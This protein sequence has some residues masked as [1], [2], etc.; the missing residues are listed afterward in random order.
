VVLPADEPALHQI[1]ALL[2]EEAWMY[3]EEDNIRI[4]HP[5]SETGEGFVRYRGTEEGRDLLD[6]V[7]QGYQRIF[8]D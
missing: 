4:V 6:V 7:F 5:E 8:M 2:Q 3:S 1:F